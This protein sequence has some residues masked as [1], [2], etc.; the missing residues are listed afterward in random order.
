APGTCMVCTGYVYVLEF[1]G[2]EKWLGTDDKVN[3][4]RYNK[5]TRDSQ[6]NKMGH[7]VGSHSVHASSDR[8]REFLGQESGVEELDQAPANFG[9]LGGNYV[10]RKRCIT[11]LQGEIGWKSEK[12]VKFGMFETSNESPGEFLEDFLG[13]RASF[14]TLVTSLPTKSEK[15]LIEGSR[16][17][18]RT[19]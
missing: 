10:A 8:G 15:A 7:K 14:T 2:G 4:I 5:V 18:I 6:L 13:W 9:K 12:V 3:F 19:Q 11:V 1:A 16:E 17:P